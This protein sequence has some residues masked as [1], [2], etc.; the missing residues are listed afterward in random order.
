MTRQQKRHVDEIVERIVSRYKAEKVILFGSVAQGKEDEQ[1][2]FDF[3][4]IKKDIP[5]RGIDRMREVRE[6]VKPAVA[7]DFL[8]YSP[9]EVEKLI[10]AGD[11][12]LKSVVAEGRVLYG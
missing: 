1:S 10:E 6:V 7:A 8:V 12:F 5:Q 4:I 9:E 3:L 11:P 2:D